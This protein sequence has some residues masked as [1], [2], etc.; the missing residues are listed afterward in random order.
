MAA[1]HLTS[2]RERILDAF[3]TLLIDDGERAATLERVARAA[4]VSKGG[5]L[6][7]FGSKEALALGLVERLDAL[8]DDDLRQ[9]AAA[10]RGAVEY[11]IRTSL[12]EAGAGQDEYERAILACSRLAQGN[13][14]AAS[15]ALRRAYQNWLAA[16]QRE[17]SDPVVAR[18]I[19]LASGGLY[20]ES[21]LRV[22]AERPDSPATDD[23]VALLREVVAARSGMR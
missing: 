10:D 13:N 18:L 5:L 3:E 21:A 9:M 8:V 19:A 6:Y 12:P 14:D 16:L 15:D 20:L 23:L 1:G 11:F 2:A 7:H 4:G 17:V 22:R